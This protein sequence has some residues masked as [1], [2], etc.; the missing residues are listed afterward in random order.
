MAGEFA[1]WWLN[2]DTGEAVDVFEHC[3]TAKENPKKFGLTK[4]FL[5]GLTCFQPAD[6][7]AIIR[8][9]MES[10]WCRVRVSRGFYVFEFDHPNRADSIFAIIHFLTTKSGAGPLSQIDVHDLRRPKMSFSVNAQTLMDP[11]AR[12]EYVGLSGVERKRLNR[13]CGNLA[14]MIRKKFL[15]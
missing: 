4:K 8:K 5:E 1:G 2:L 6:R 3:Q 11:E 10:G 15:R 9:A 14:L 7:E 12:E 13:M